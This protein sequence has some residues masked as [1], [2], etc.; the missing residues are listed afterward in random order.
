MGV[1]INNA[2]KLV[3][4]GSG[5]SGMLRCGPGRT[6]GRRPGA[7]IVSCVCGFLS[8]PLCSLCPPRSDMRGPTSSYSTV[9]LS[10]L[11]SVQIVRGWLSQ[12]GRGGGEQGVGPPPGRGSGDCGHA[13]AGSYHR[14]RL[15]HRNGPAGGDD[16]AVACRGGRWVES[17]R[18]LAQHPER[19][20]P[21]WV[22]LTAT[23]E[24]DVSA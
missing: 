16:E 11:S 18:V 7:R 20:L 21:A 4:Q 24:D 5:R 10:S 8:G 14:R 23:V 3:S 13:C 17:R 15:P 12:R 9:S 19:C 6:Q 22:V 1:G 2:L